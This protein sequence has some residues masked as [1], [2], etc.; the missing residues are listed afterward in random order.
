MF[1]QFQEFSR[2]KLKRHSIRIEI[3]NSSICDNPSSKPSTASFAGGRLADNSLFSLRRQTRAGEPCEWQI[4]VLDCKA[5][6]LFDHNCEPCRDIDVQLRCAVRI[7]ERNEADSRIACCVYNS[8]LRVQ[9]S[10]SFNRIF[11]SEITITRSPSNVTL[12]RLSL[13]C[14][15]RDRFRFYNINNPRPREYYYEYIGR[16]F[17]HQNHHVPIIILVIKLYRHGDERKT[18]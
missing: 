18:R 7:S 17:I 8:P 2:D 6:T 1:I 15:Q 13:N 11:S 5:V 12:T 9:I 4:E 16:R 3:R 14:E 10:T